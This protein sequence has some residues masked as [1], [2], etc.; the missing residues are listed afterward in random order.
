M[1]DQDTL[2]KL[3]AMRLSAMATAIEDQRTNTTFASLSFE[4]RLG[5]IV[6]AEW[7]YRQNCS[8]RAR[9][10]KAKLKIGAASLE[11][12]DLSP[13][14]N[15]DGAL[16][17]QLKTGKWVE[18]RHNVIIT[19]K[20]GSGKTFLAC[21]LAQQACRLGF[22]A[23]YRRAPRLAHEL[24]IARADGSL[25]KVLA[26]LERTHVLVIDDWGLAPLKDQERRDL[27]E[28]FE[29]RYDAT[30]T[31]ITSQLPVETWHDTIGDPTIADAICDRL[32]HNAF[33]VALNAD[34]SK[35]KE[36]AAK[37]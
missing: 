2:G 10:G 15:L 28:V 36:A 19:G 3:R 22:K 37:K 6:D 21:A 23:L 25:A 14:R 32:V 8:L 27:L 5:M 31:I 33:K 4:E 35:R 34:E 12:L 16:I 20:T 11:D 18:N 30:S 17:R 7:L 24:A 26:T 29:D 1:L 9:L 13:K